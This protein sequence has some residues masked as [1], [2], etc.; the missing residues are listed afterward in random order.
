MKKPTLKLESPETPAPTSGSWFHAMLLP[1][2]SQNPRLNQLQKSLPEFLEPPWLM[3]MAVTT[4][5]VQELRHSVGPPQGCPQ[6]SCSACPSSP[7]G[8]PAAPQ[9]TEHPFCRRHKKLLNSQRLRLGSRV[10]SG[11]PILP[12]S[13]ATRGQWLGSIVNSTHL[14]DR[15]VPVGPQVSKGQRTGD[16]GNS[17]N[18]LRIPHHF[19]Q[20]WLQQLPTRLLNYSS[21]KMDC[22]QEFKG[23]LLHFSRAQFPWCALFRFTLS[24]SFF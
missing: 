22:Q 5:Q 21:L 2:G 16:K 20:G 10:L 1:L 14:H 9:L 3:G 19:A 17:E 8:P 6:A 7:L 13:S 15:P 18:K 23:Y 12:S 24:F 4:S 11:N